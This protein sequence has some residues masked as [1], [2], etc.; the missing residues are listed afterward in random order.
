MYIQASELGLALMLLNDTF[1]DLYEK[2]GCQLV[3]KTGINRVRYIWGRV[4]KYHQSEAGK[5]CF[6]ASDRLKFE[7]LPRKYRTL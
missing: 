5:D 6:L 3:S 4:S 2:I 7:T 1:L